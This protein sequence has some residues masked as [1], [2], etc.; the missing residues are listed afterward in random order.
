MGD[1]E[2]RKLAD[3]GVT[4]AYLSNLVMV[5]ISTV[6]CEVHEVTKSE[7]DVVIRDH[8]GLW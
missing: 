3:Y 7:R 5:D 2:K 4:L 8:N 6:C 1:S